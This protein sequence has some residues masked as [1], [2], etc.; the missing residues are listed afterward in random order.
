[1]SRYLY[2]CVKCFMSHRSYLLFLQGVEVYDTRMQN[3]SIIFTL[4]L[5]LRGF[6]V[7]HTRT[8]NAIS[9]HHCVIICIAVKVRIV[10]KCGIVCLHKRCSQW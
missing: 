7:Y 8:Q 6:E 10:G 5:V 3:A 4:L 9:K 1:M 2:L